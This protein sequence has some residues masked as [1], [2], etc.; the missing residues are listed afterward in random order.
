MGRADAAQLLPVQSSDGADTAH[1]ARAFVRNRVL[2]VLV[3]AALGAAFALAFVTHAPNRLLSGR[4]I[5]LLSASSGSQALALVPGLILLATPFLPQGRTVHALTAAAAAAFIVALCWLAGA[6]AAALAAEAPPAARTSLG[7]GFWLLL[8]CAALALIDSMRRLD[9]RPATGILA[10]GAVLG[11]LVLLGANGS[12]DALSLAKEYALRRDEFAA[13]LGRHVVIVLAALVPTVLIGTPLG[14]LA[15]RRKQ[16]GA[17]LFPVL[18]LIQTI[19]SI[20][21]FGLLIAPLSGL[22][23]VLPGLARFGISGIGLAPAVIAL[24]FYSLLP[25][26]RNT[27]EGLAGVSPAA[28]EAA[29][30]MG[31]TRRQIFWRVQAPLAAPVF[32]AGLR[33]TLVQAIGLAAVAALIGAGGLGSIMF[34]GVFANAADLTLLGAAPVILLAVAADAV[35]RLAESWTKRTPA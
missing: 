4:A 17:S 1:R 21:L 26:V 20:A 24:I 7:S 9:P 5:S 2:L 19:P 3:A 23:S 30:A 35:L 22:A 16:V 12:L 27:V 14:L 18:N 6:N 10:G 28:I 15:Y 29:R 13:A 32:L 34:E 33:I 31:M 8:L 25:I 11:A